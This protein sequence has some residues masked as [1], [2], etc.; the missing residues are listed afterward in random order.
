MS[1]IV[2]LPAYSH[3]L[4]REFV[5]DK[6]LIHLYCCVAHRRRHSTGSS[7]PRTTWSE[8]SATAGITPTPSRCSGHFTGFQWDSGSPTKWLCW[9][10]RCG[11]QPL[12]RISVT[13]YRPTYR[14]GL[15]A[16][17]TLHCWPS[18]GHVPNWLNALSLSQPHPSGTLYL[19]TF[20]CARV[21]PYLSA[22]WKP[23]CLDWLSPVLLQ[24]PLY[25]RTSR[26]YRNVLLLYYYYLFTIETVT[27]FI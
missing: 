12:R 27:Q 24:A 20:D 7:V 6:S 3:C 21:F 15:C 23:I 18:H 1:S 17:R 22:A 5:A 9:H 14:F 11:P 25:L 19:L 2:P 4:R 10:T 8:S 13:W 26:R 16:H